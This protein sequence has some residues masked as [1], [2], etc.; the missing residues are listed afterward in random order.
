MNV[1]PWKVEWIEVPVTVSTSAYTAG[2]VVGGLLECAVDQYRGGGF[3]QGVRL[4][5]DHAQSEPYTL[6][7]FDSKPAVIADGDA[8]AATVANGALCIGQIAIA[9]TD[10]ATWGSEKRAQV[11]VTDVAPTFGSLQSGKLYAYLVASETPD[12][13]GVNDLTMHLCVWSF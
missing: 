2:D 11:D 9:S 13:N 6:Y 1:L 4:I 5:D 8:W 3:V 10:Y 12:Y 7:L